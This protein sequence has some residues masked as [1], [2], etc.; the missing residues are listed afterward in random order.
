MVCR[1][2]R[3]PVAIGLGGIADLVAEPLLER[4]EARL[5]PGE[6]TD[7]QAPAQGARPRCLRV[8]ADERRPLAGHRV[9]VHSNGEPVGVRGIRTPYGAVGY[10]MVR[11]DDGLEVRIILPLGVPSEPGQQKEKKPFAERA[12]FNR[13]GAAAR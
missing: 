3:L 9:E 10:T 8:Q 2:R 13:Y 11:T 6:Q 7:G 4:R 1:S 12:W 5:H